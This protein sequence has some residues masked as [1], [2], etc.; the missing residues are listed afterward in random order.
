MDKDRLREEEGVKRGE[1]RERGGKK[2]EGKKEREMQNKRQ[3]EKRAIWVERLRKIYTKQRKG[4]GYQ[5]GEG[6]R[7]GGKDEV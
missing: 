2:G 6:S 1:R 5:E 3:R 4:N 7:E